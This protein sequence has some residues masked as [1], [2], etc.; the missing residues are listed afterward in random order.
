MARTD[1]R[2]DELTPEMMMGSLKGMNSSATLGPDGWH[3]EELKTLP[4][5]A[6]AQIVEIFRRCE[7]ERRLPQVLLQS[8]TAVIPKGAE[9]QEVLSLRPIAVLATL[10]RWYASTRQQHFTVWFQQVAGPEIYSYLPG[11]SA[12]QA[13]CDIGS[14][15]DEATQL[16]IISTDAG[17]AFPST[18][19]HTQASV[20]GHLQHLGVP[21]GLTD[22]FRDAYGRGPPRVQYWDLLLL[23][24]TKT[25]L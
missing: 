21:R 24:F 12:V 6:I 1:M 16:H 9:P 15:I 14:R 7:A 10:Y 2:L 3:V 20:V 18:H 8:W 22:I 25:S 19:T 23:I 4:A 13:G 17:K 11:K 5:P